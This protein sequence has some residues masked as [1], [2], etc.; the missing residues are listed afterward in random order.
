MTCDP[1][2]DYARIQPDWTYEG[3]GYGQL[4]ATG[5]GTRVNLRITTDLRPGSS[6]G[7]STPA[8]AWSRATAIS[9]PCR[10]RRCRRR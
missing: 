2:F 6:A 3:D 1:I 5:D 8:P 7:A 10:G 9:W 4:V